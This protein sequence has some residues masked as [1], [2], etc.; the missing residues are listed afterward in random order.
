[1]S[2]YDM[3]LA[4]GEL[5]PWAA[6]QR[7]DVRRAPRTPPA[8]AGKRR[9]GASSVAGSPKRASAHTRAAQEQ[10]QH[11]QQEKK[12]KNAL[13]AAAGGHSA[14]STE[15]GS[16][17]KKATKLSRVRSL[18]TPAPATPPPGPAVS[19]C[20]AAASLPS[21]RR[22]EEF[23]LSSTTDEGGLS[24]DGGLTSVTKRSGVFP[25][26]EHTGALCAKT[27]NDN[28][29]VWAGQ[30]GQ[31]A[32]PPPA[33]PAEQG[34]MPNWDGDVSVPVVLTADDV[35]PLPVEDV[36]SVWRTTWGRSKAS[37]G[38]V[39]VPCCCVA[40]AAEAADVMQR[41]ARLAEGK[42]G[43][44]VHELAAHLRLPGDL[45][46]RLARVA[47]AVNCFWHEHSGALPLATGPNQVDPSRVGLF[48]L[49]LWTAADPSASLGVPP[50]TVRPISPG[51]AAAMRCATTHG[52]GNPAAAWQDLARWA[53]CI[54]LVDAMCREHGNPLRVRA[55]GAQGFLALPFACVVA[56][57][58]DA[59]RPLT[60][61]Y[62]NVVWM[63]NVVIC[64]ATSGIDAGDAWDRPVRHP[65]GGDD[66]DPLGRAVGAESD[67][68]VSQ[69]LVL[70]QE[71]ARRAPHARLGCS[72]PLTDDQD[73]ALAGGFRRAA[74]AAPGAPPPRAHGTDPERYPSLLPQLWRVYSTKPGD[75]V[76]ELCLNL[77]LPG[78]LCPRAVLY[79][80]CR[81]TQASMCGPAPFAPPDPPADMIEWKEHG[82]GQIAAGDGAAPA[83]KLKA[84]WLAAL[85]GR[86]V[87]FRDVSALNAFLG[88]GCC[89]ETPCAAIEAALRLLL[90]GGAPEEK[91]AAWKKVGAW[92]KTLGLLLAHCDW[93]PPPG[94]Y[95]VAPVRDLPDASEAIAPVSFLCPAS[96]AV[97]HLDPGDLFKGSPADAARPSTPN[98]EGGGVVALSGAPCLPVT[99][100]HAVVHPL[101]RFMLERVNPAGGGAEPVAGGSVTHVGHHVPPHGGGEFRAAQADVAWAA[102]RLEKFAASEASW[103]AA[104]DGVVGREDAAR[105]ALAAS[106]DRLDDVLA[107]LLAEGIARERIRTDERAESTAAGVLAEQLAGTAALRAAAEAQLAVW[108]VLAAHA[109]GHGSLAAQ[110][111]RQRAGAC[112]LE[113]PERETFLR[114]AI[115]LEAIRFESRAAALAAAL[116]A[117][118]GTALDERHARALECLVFAWTSG[119]IFA[120]RCQRNDRCD[121]LRAACLSEE[122]A[123]RLALHREARTSA[124][125]LRC[126]HAAVAGALALSDAA[127]RSA[128]DIRHRE[129]HAREVVAREELRSADAQGSALLALHWDHFNAWRSTVQKW[130]AITG[131]ILKDTASEKTGV[132]ANSLERSELSGRA[133]IETL[134]A[135]EREETR[136]AFGERLISQQ[137]ADLATAA[138]AELQLLGQQADTVVGALLLAH[139][140]NVEEAEQRA[141]IGKEARRDAAGAEPAAPE[142]GEP[143]LELPAASA[144]A[145]PAPA[146]AKRLDAEACSLCD[147][148]A[149]RLNRHRLDKPGDV[150][151]ELLENCGPRL[152]RRFL[153]ALCVG[154]HQKHASS[155]APFVPPLAFM[156]AWLASLS[157]PGTSQLLGDQV[158]PIMQELQPVYQS[159]FDPSLAVDVRKWAHTI[160]VLQAV[161][162]AAADGGWAVQSV[163]EVVAAG[164]VSTGPQLVAVGKAAGR[165]SQEP[166]GVLLGEGVGLVPGLLAA[167]GTGQWRVWAPAKEATLWG[168]RTA[169]WRLTS[170]ACVPKSAPT[171][172]A[173]CHAETARVALNAQDHRYSTVLSFF[174]SSAAASS[175]IA[176]SLL[177]LSVA[178]ASTQPLRP[179]TTTA[180]LVTGSMSPPGDSAS[181]DEIEITPQT[182]G[183]NMKKQL[184]EN[185]PVNDPQPARNHPALSSGPAGGQ[186]AKVTGSMHVVDKED[187]SSDS[188]GEQPAATAK[189]DAAEARGNPATDAA[190]ED[191]EYSFPDD[192][193]DGDLGD[194]PAAERAET[195]PGPAETAAAPPPAQPAP[196]SL[197]GASPQQAAA[198]APSQR[199][200]ESDE[201]PRERATVVVTGK[202][203]FVD[204]PDSDD[205][206]E[207]GQQQAAAKEEEEG[208]EKSAAEK[209]EAPT[210]PPQKAATPAVPSLELSALLQ[211]P[212]AARAKTDSEEERESRRTTNAEEADMPD[213]RDLVPAVNA[214]NPQSGK[215][216]A[217]G[218]GTEAKPTALL[219][220]LLTAANNAPSGAPSNDLSTD[221]DTAR[222]QETH[223]PLQTT[224]GEVDG[225]RPEKEGA[226]QRGSSLTIA[227]K[228]SPVEASSV[229]LT[230]ATGDTS[231]SDSTEETEEDEEDEEDEEEEEEDDETSS[232]G[233]DPAP[234]RNPAPKPAA[235][236]PPSSGHCVGQ[237]VVVRDKT[238]EDWKPGTVTAVINGKPQVKLDGQLRGFHWAFVDSIAKAPAASEADTAAARNES[239]P[240]SK[241]SSVGISLDLNSRNDASS[242]PSAASANQ[243]P[244]PSPSGQREPRVVGSMGGPQD[245]DFSSSGS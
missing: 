140:L 128:S 36:E 230:S 188:E 4:V 44:A 107:A 136:R 124:E 65:A 131:M 200:A 134:S 151:D 133:D 127:F 35:E 21:V 53:K 108:G 173:R 1:M 170:E 178:F 51:V 130:E 59:G 77:A 185:P 22:H 179:P 218:P 60:G 227:K 109:E 164:A 205:D 191:D 3:W 34:W 118:H 242:S 237:R 228:K 139:S 87:S 225:P 144:P 206:E 238:E 50:G 16:P 166:P 24:S 112:A 19:D 197:H 141:R 106:L 11:Q 184:A 224:G 192:S 97:L 231:S 115:Q 125:M 100:V 160:C 243:A 143:A 198:P 29:F 172:A 33:S 62:A 211:A 119:R 217:P 61:R 187:S 195:K 46:S 81:L 209:E 113:F 114:S 132:L 101:A 126:A 37:V 193:E 6:A 142:D 171:L 240:A 18:P 17:L 201:P 203:D 41:V 220:A 74:D 183:R 156:I 5:P 73:A 69:A 159:A 177:L 42:P 147:S 129:L 116:R 83:G 89:V 70:L 14:P 52:A 23:F 104:V 210:Q 103:R 233:T 72:V 135:A 158:T 165:A 145:A 30:A 244:Q 137:L 10:Q 28:E 146:A 75:V 92:V 38:V 216:D 219:A 212:A 96:C 2:D 148:F 122:A 78:D 15:P 82:P 25:G 154:V 76:D 95:L 20:C 49:H 27:D 245:D 163:G 196:T 150:V 117:A 39:G 102:R 226:P 45:P 236:A 222:K 32:E 176:A 190:R 80:L 58:G 152:T 221:P 213:R 169:E 204:D 208:D 98:S 86:L 56:G 55:P 66:S 161:G 121:L 54:V 214:S 94:C 202:M 168:L 157:R 162:C 234:A 90:G 175:A 8:G 93:T 181:D 123:R 9:G 120:S 241:K 31:M 47:V 174:G 110:E 229:S 155:A 167:S 7:L 111:R 194:A 88:G 84:R 207:Q 189:P 26:P 239:R 48:L 149:A 105:A 67:A 13:F 138:P 79:R 43:T 223:S 186:P 215:E 235:P 182:D 63:D 180:C 199:A 40:S 232:S 57:D 91:R 85:V 153:A 71:W 99:R 12:R 68:T 64:A